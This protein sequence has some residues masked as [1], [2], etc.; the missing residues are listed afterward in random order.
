[1][2]VLR[3]QPVSLRDAFAF[4]QAHH[5]H[6]RPPQGGK[7]AIGVSLSGKLVGTVIVGRPVARAYDN[8]LVAEVTCCTDGTTNACSMLYGAA[9]RAARAM[10][11]L[12]L[13][14]YTLASE[15]GVSLKAAG[16][17]NVGLAGGRTWDRPSRMR[18]DT[19]PIE[20]KTLW[21]TGWRGQLPA[22]PAARRDS[23]RYP[24][25]GGLPCGAS[26]RK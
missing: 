18:T 7:F 26:I 21:E 23:T 2:T 5:L 10:G 19:H 9:W 16:Y 20:Q 1:M 8:G 3:L 17:R 6:P 11:Y 22:G 15:S 24:P 14:T 13:I 12:R 25:H 4:V